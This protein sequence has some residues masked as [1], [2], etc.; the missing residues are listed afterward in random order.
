MLLVGV[1]GLLERAA[2]EYL[3]RYYEGLPARVYWGTAATFA[4]EL[5]AH[6]HDYAAA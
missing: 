2:R 4:E 5:D 6:V 1:D 3:G